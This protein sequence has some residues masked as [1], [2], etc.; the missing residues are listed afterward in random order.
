MNTR[1]KAEKGQTR[2]NMAQ[3]SRG[4]KRDTTTSSILQHNR[5]G[6]KIPVRMKSLVAALCTSR[7]CGDD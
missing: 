6:H 7:R 3:D 2:N 1:R 5:E 4:V